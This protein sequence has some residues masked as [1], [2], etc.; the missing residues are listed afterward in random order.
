LKAEGIAL[1]MGDPGIAEGTPNSML[2]RNYFVIKANDRF[3]G[4]GVRNILI[5][6][7]GVVTSQA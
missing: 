4:S 3:A 5:A 2:F 6:S 1:A 7:F